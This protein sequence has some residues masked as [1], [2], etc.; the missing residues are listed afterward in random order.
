VE[1]NEKVFPVLSLEAG[2]LWPKVWGYSWA[3]QPYF[4]I[5]WVFIL[6]CKEFIPFRLKWMNVTCRMKIQQLHSQA[7]VVPMN[8]LS[9]TVTG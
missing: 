8:R 3:I 6:H 1:Y 9:G 5:L 4:H 2:F 7:N